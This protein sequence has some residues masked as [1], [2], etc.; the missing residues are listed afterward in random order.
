[1]LTV[2]EI[3]N[4]LSTSLINCGC[5]AVTLTDAHDVRCAIN[6]LNI[7]KSDGVS[8]LNTDHFINACDELSVHVDMLFSALLIH[9]FAPADTCACTVVHC[10]G[11]WAPP[12]IFVCPMHCIAA[13]DR[14]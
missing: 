6:S 11:V 3:C 9:G 4:N 8:C 7:R 10:S 13:L 1:M 14:I 5:H 12:R 2:Q